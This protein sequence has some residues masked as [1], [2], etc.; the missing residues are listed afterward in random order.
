MLSSPKQKFC[1]SDFQLILQDYSVHYKRY[2]SQAAGVL[3]FF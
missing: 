2:R 3:N 1:L